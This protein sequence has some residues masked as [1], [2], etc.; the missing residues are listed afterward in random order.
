MSRT[1]KKLIVGIALACGFIIT[2]CGL[3]AEQLFKARSPTVKRLAAHLLE[4]RGNLVGMTK[5]DLAHR[6]GMPDRTSDRYA[7]L[8]LPAIDRP[9]S[10]MTSDLLLR[11]GVGEAVLGIGYAWRDFKP[12][13]TNRFAVEAW[14]QADDATKIPMTPDFIGRWNAGELRQEYAT[15]SQFQQRLGTPLFVDQW[16]YMMGDWDALVF[17]FNPKGEVTAVYSGFDD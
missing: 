2:T 16:R 11:L 17:A 14:R 8:L 1:W 9:T 10:G 12:A 6:F 4:L 7:L 5:S 3:F 13:K 15:L